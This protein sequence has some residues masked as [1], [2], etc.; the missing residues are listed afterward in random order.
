MRWRWTCRRLFLLLGMT[1]FLALNVHPFVVSC[2]R[3]GPWLG[4]ELRAEY[5]LA[6]V[7]G[8]L[9]LREGWF[10]WPGH[11]LFDPGTFD[12]SGLV[13]TVGD[14]LYM[15]SWETLTDLPLNA[16]NGA[17]RGIASRWVQAG[18]SEGPVYEYYKAMQ[19]RGSAGFRAQDETF[20]AAI[21]V[22]ATPGVPRT[23]LEP[24][25]VPV[26]TDQR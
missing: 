15:I 17:V 24:V 10:T 18:L 19:L 6:V 16:S 23:G 11:E 13:L 5:R 1:A 2:D 8:M 22:I 4:P 14:R 21:E 7:R 26:H 25:A 9:N 20:C 12:W 3:G